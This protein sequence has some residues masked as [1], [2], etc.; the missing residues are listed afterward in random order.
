VGGAKHFAAVGRRHPV[1]SCFE[2]LSSY[3]ASDSVDR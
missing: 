3:V 1:I 2:Q